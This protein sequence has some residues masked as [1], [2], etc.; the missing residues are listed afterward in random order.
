MAQ[1][2]AGAH[3][4]KLLE[5]RARGGF[6]AQICESTF[7]RRRRSSPA[8]NDELVARTFG[9]LAT[10]TASRSRS[11]HSAARDLRIPLRHRSRECRDRRSARAREEIFFGRSARFSE[12]HSRRRA[13]KTGSAE[14][15]RDKLAQASMWPS[16]IR[17]AEPLTFGTSRPRSAIISTRISL[18]RPISIPCVMINSS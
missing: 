7:R 9:E 17:T 16:K 14:R 3:R 13:Q 11:Q 5:V 12:R 4:A 8:A 18:G 1:A 6:H 10:R 15:R 2:E